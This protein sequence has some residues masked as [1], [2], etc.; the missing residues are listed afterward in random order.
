MQTKSKKRIGVIGNPGAWSSELLADTIERNTGFRA[1]IELPKLQLD[2]ERDRV[3]FGE[4]NLLDLDALIIKKIGRS[5]APGHLNRLEML[6]FVQQRGVPV[7]SDPARIMGVLS[8][9]SCTVTLKLARIPMPPTL[10]TEDVER[11]QAA[12]RRFG[13]AVLKPLYS[14]KARGMRIIETGP[15]ADEQIRQY[16]AEH[17][18]MY[19]QK[20][21]QLPDRDLGIAFLGGRY[22]ATYARMGNTESW[23]TTVREG[24]RYEAY[25]PDAA[26]IELAA[27]AQAPFG[28]DFTTVDVA[29]TPDG[30][31]V[32]EVS[33]FGGLRG[34][35]EGCGIDAAQRYLD[36][37][38][39]RIA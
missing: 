38:L 1:L 16:H 22:L 28:L 17:K 21:I 37:V 11:V 8:R 2:L 23:N 3:L 13:R 31:T 25:Q 29:E 20:L 6:R 24:G 4:L 9:L 36:H 10:I 18:V 39:E 33:A 14:T 27:R 30:P 19:V 35:E 26:I 32:F 7:F 15:Q 12:V 34:L 5:Y